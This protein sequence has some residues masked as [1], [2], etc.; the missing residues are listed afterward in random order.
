[1]CKHK[2]ADAKTGNNK[3][4]KPCGTSQA[5]KLVMTQENGCTEDA[6]KL[7]QT[8][9]LLSKN[10]PLIYGHKVTLNAPTNNSYKLQSFFKNFI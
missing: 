8:E 10:S 6:H 7:S 1:M 3:P 5:K 2:R 4:L 9:H